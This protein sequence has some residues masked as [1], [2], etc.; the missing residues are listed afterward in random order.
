MSPYYKYKKEKL[1]KKFESAK[2]TFLQ[3]TDDT[4]ILI[5]KKKS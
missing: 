4:I 5:I 2:D 3:T 1:E